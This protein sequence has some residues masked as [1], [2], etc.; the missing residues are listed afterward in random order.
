MWWTVVK[1]FIWIACGSWRKVGRRNVMV[2][3]NSV[4]DKY[5]K[6]YCLTGIK[7]M[8]LKYILEL[9]RVWPYFVA[10][11][12]HFYPFLINL[13]RDVPCY[14]ARCRKAQ[15]A[16]LRNGVHCQCNTGF[17]WAGT[18]K[19]IEKVNE[20]R[21][22]CDFQL[23]SMNRKEHK[24]HNMWLLLKSCSLRVG[25]SLPLFMIVDQGLVEVIYDSCCCWS[26][27]LSRCRWAVMITGGWFMNCQLSFKVLSLCLAVFEGR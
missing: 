2:S 6:W 10:S 27:K 26:K 14:E 24:V 4:W 1:Y 9:L 11:Y 15:C 8:F 19:T 21:L 13:I 12:F 18:W 17:L 20:R 25:V 5:D 16:A 22:L 23:Q 3:D 7:V